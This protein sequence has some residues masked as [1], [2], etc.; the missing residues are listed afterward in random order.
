MQMGF[1]FVAV[2]AYAVIAGCAGGKSVPG[3]SAVVTVSAYGPD[4][5]GQHAHG[6]GGRSDVL[7]SSEGA[8]QLSYPPMD[9]RSCNQSNTACLLGIGVVDGTAKII[10]SS[11]TSATVA[12]NLSYQVGRSYSLNA[13]GHQF[14][15]EIPSDVQALHA[16][17]VIS[18]RIEVAYGEVVHLSL[19]YGVDVAVCAQKHY[20]GEIMPDRSVCQGY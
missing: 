18:K 20:A 11:A 15:Q 19:P 9:L 10:S 4:L 12:I 6:V 13:D 7:E 3:N 5:F 8:T 17:Q 1:R 16:N 2:F 14:K